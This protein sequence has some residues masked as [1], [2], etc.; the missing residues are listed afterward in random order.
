MSYFLHRIQRTESS[1]Q[2]GI[3]V[4]DTLDAAVLSFWGRMKTGYSRTENIYVSCMITDDAGKIV[5]PYNMTWIQE[6]LSMGNKF[7]LHHIQKS[8]KSYDK[9]IDELESFETACGNLAAMME[10][11]YN[12]P[13]YP[14]VSFVHCM[15]TDMRSGGIVL[16]DREWHKIAEPEPEPEEPVQEESGQA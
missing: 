14:D 2:K 10:Y 3:E 7:Y 8:G 11:G 16:L 13:K 5:E 15:I 9:S 12:N 6:G 4:H 1:S